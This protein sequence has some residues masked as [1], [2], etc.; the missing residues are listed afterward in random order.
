[1]RWSWRQLWL[2]CENVHKISPQF[3]L[4]A[5]FFVEGKHSWQFHAENMAKPT[6]TPEGDKLS[7]AQLMKSSEG[8]KLFPRRQVFPGRPVAPFF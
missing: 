6:K 5:N 8:D 3:D 2:S 7:E 4:A 1:V